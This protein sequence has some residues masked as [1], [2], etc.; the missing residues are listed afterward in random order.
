MEQPP[1]IDRF[2]WRGIEIETTYTPL[3]WGASAHL[4]VRSVSPE[5]APLPISETGYLSHFH[6][7]GTIEARG[8]NIVAQVTAWLD[9]A[10]TGREWLA[11]EQRDRKLRLF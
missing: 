2:H 1:Q 7:V 5:H 6:Q 11:C 9:E 10:S 4:E 8:G 3:K